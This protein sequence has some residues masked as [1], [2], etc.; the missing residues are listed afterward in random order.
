MDSRLSAQRQCGVNDSSLRQITR[1]GNLTSGQRSRRQSMHLRPH[2]NQL[3]TFSSKRRIIAVTKKA[4]FHRFES[5]TLKD[6]A[7]S[8]P[9][10]GKVTNLQR[11]RTSNLRRRDAFN[12]TSIPEDSS[13]RTKQEETDCMR[14][15]DVHK[16]SGWYSHDVR[17]TLHDRL[18][19]NQNG[20]FCL[21]LFGANVDKVKCKS[22]I[23]AIDKKTKDKEGSC[24]VW[25][26]RWWK[27]YTGVITATSND[28][29]IYLMLFSSY[30]F[31]T[32]AG[33]PVKKIL[34]KLNLSDHRLF[35]DGR[36]RLHILLD[37]QDL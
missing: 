28:Q 1:L 35:N 34:L 12:H 37:S 33:N 17:D 22:M 24:R 13:M 15:Y 8:S 9:C 3:V 5:K 11:C 36:W 4:I 6:M 31:N 2:G 18:K 25:R 14:I 20:V 30:R 29:M 16:F 27:T 23:Q 7:A 26:I 10:Y 32:T 21:S 19:R